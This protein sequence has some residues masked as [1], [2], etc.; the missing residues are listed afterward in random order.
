MNARWT[1]GLLAITLSAACAP[2]AA[3]TGTSNGSTP[4]GTAS[5]VS[6]APVSAPAAAPTVVVLV[7]H[8]EKSTEGGDDPALTAIG[9][10]RAEA[11]AATLRSAGV[12]AVIVS[13]RRRTHETAAPLAQARGIVPDTVRLGATVPEHAAAVAR[14]IRERYW[15]RTVLVVGHSN[16]VPPII[17]ALGGPRLPDICDPV[18]SHLFV[19]TLRENGEPQLI[20][21]R[22]GA[23]DTPSPG[24]CPEMQ[25]R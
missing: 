16:T 6:A 14:R 1:A 21:S 22:Y 10:E 20:Q 7:R 4:P 24:T 12:D 3:T 9:R 13:E 17:A 5:P 2:G 25:A 11:L 8:A 15:G 19:M 23:F 18:H